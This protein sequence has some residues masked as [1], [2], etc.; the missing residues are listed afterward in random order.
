MQDYKQS[1][2]IKE[3][4][5]RA[6]VSL[7]TVSRVINNNGLVKPS[8]REKVEHAI[9]DLNYRPNIIARRLAGG[10]SLFVGLV[11]HNPSP[12]YLT[13][14]LLGSLDACRGDGS[15]LVIED[16]GNHTPYANPEDTARSLKAAGL[17]GVIITPPLSNHD[18]LIEA[19]EGSGLPVVR[20]AP[21]DIYQDSLLV[22]MDD[23]L[24][25]KKMLQ[26]L[27]DLGHRD[28]GFVRGPDD[29]PSSRHR[30]EGFRK[31]M[32]AEG[33]N[34]NE[35]FQIGGDFTYRSGFDAGRM[36]LSL[37]ARP[38]AIFASNDDMAAGVVAA[39]YM[40]GLRVPDD[41]SVVGFDD[42]EIAKNTWP[43]LTTVRQPIA[44]MARRSVRMLTAYMRGD[45]AGLKTSRELLD[46]EIVLRDSAK[47]L[48]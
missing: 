10:K 5:E 8:T 37:D 40:L 23:T 36:L 45:K 21:G 27:V 33:I 1:V 24:A 30:H 14:I 44:E 7:M 6:G 9:S 42:T 31:G 22:A 48:D 18:P 35:A 12:G 15:H 13:K 34:V 39:A 47:R 4:A 20:I 26:H 17:D 32:E 3:V 29:H 2:T 19:L 43:E 25:A 16:L 38:T 46:F 11:Y 28:I 41:I